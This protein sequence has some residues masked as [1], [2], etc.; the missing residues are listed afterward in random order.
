[1]NDSV[2]SINAC[3]EA[4]TYYANTFDHSLKMTLL[5]E[6]SKVRLAVRLPMY[7]VSGRYTIGAASLNCLIQPLAGLS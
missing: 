2:D 6:S 4:L 1:M 7:R 5:V 3:S